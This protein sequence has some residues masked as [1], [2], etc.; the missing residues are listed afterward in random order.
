MQIKESVRR[1]LTERLRVRRKERWPELEDVRVRFRAP[2]AY[3]D[4]VLSQD[5]V[6]PLCRLRYMGSADAWGFACYLASKGGYEPSVLPSG[7]FT[8]P[9]EHALDTACGLYL[10]DMSAWTDL[11]ASKRSPPTH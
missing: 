8:G 2:F 5:E 11:F 3:V 9:P 10:G 6:L 1:S 7:S 4:A